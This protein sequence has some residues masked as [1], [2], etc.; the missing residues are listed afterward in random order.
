M[1]K[2]KA[3][4]LKVVADNRKARHTYFIESSL[5]AGVMLT[6]SEVKSLR[7][8]KATIGESYAQAKDGEARAKG[9]R[10]GCES[11]TT[12]AEESARA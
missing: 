5:E 11:A 9:A 3:P 8:G 1:A 12:S 4:D 2:K 7:S 6:G 10:D